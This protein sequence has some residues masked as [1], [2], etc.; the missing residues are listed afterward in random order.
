MQD[1]MFKSAQRVWNGEMRR[2]AME[3]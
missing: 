2:S 1:F 3:K